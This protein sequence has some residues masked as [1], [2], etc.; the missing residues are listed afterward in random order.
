MGLMFSHDSFRRDM[1]VFL[2]RIDA[3]AVFFSHWR[4]SSS[5]IT[6]TI[7]Y[8]SSGLF[9]RYA[10]Q[11]SNVKMDWFHSRAGQPVSAFCSLVLAACLSLLR[12]DNIRLPGAEKNMLAS[13]GFPASAEIWYS[14]M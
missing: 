7:V 13:L 9:W 10:V 8:A 2:W 12:K 5:D 6:W 3:A 14:V 11:Y 4:F 1:I